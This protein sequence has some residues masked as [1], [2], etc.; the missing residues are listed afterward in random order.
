MNERVMVLKK[1]PFFFN[2]CGS[3]EFSAGLRTLGWGWH[4]RQPG[5]AEFEYLSLAASTH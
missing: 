5:W 4:A 3:A 1:I 2:V